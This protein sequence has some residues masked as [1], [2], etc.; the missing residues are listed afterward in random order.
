MKH[1]KLPIDNDFKDIFF[2]I[3][4][5]KKDVVALLMNTIKYATTDVKVEGEVDCYLHIIV[6]DMN[7]FVYESKDKIFSIRSP[8]RVIQNNGELVFYTQHIAQIDSIT[9]S[10]VLSLLSDDRFESPNSLDFLCLLEETFETEVD[11]IWAFI[12][13]L[14]SFEDGYLRYD[15]DPDN[16]DGRLHPLSHLDICYTTA[17][18]YKI[19][20]YKR[21]CVEFFTQLLNN[22]KESL[23]LEK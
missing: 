2:D 21:P 7:R 11:H 9:S 3:I 22:K 20:T 8:F 12:I 6:D 1:F 10:N 16:E 5:S 18:T 19:G 15:Y 23:F 17:S 14:I 13:E 4:R